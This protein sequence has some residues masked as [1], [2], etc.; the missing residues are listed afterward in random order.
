MTLKALAFPCLLSL[1]ATSA[2]AAKPVVQTVVTDRY[3]FE[4]RLAGDGAPIVHVADEVPEPLFLYLTSERFTVWWRARHSCDKTLQ[5]KVKVE[6]D[7]LLLDVAVTPRRAQQCEPQ[8]TVFE[9]VVEGWG[10]GPREVKSAGAVGSIASLW[11][12]SPSPSRAKELGTLD[13]RVRERPALR[14]LGERIAWR[15]HVEGE[16]R[17]AISAYRWLVT[18]DELHWRTPLYHARVFHNAVFTRTKGGALAALE[19]LLPGVERLRARVAA[20]STK[21][22]DDSELA[23]MKRELVA[24]EAFLEPSLRYLALKWH[25]EALH[26]WHAATRTYRAYLR[27]FPTS[28]HAAS[29]RFFYGSALMHTDD[30]AEAKEQFRLA[31]EGLEDPALRELADACA[32]VLGLE[33]DTHKQ[34]A[35][36]RAPRPAVPSFAI[37]PKAAEE[38]FARGAALSRS[39]SKKSAAPGP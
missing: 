34:L 2:A 29:L 12:S 32:V 15:Y 14:R 31:A 21:H 24:L 19:S 6:G 35:P 20:T 1:L 30:L 11:V 10:N 9:T 4:P 7:R 28:A 23:E 37:F 25:S 39:S 38:Q 26:R 17:A 3:V 18:L 8:A 16:T 33:S 5:P 13:D 27:L 36:C 22:D